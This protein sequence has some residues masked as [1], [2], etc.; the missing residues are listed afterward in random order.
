MSKNSK[1]Q[2]SKPQNSKDL[3]SQAYN[4]PIIVRN[5]DGEY[6]PVG[7]FSSLAFITK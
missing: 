7:K 5:E 6:A 4:N 2:N 1:P 3:V